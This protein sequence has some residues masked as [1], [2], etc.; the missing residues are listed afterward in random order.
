MTHASV[1]VKIGI[2]RSTLYRHWPDV[3]EMRNDLFKRATTPPKMAPPTD[4]PLRTDLIWRLGILV[5]AL[6]E[7][8]WGH[9]APQVI[10]AAATDDGARD[11]IT[12]FMKERR[13]TVRAVFATADARGELAPAA[14]VEYLIQ[15][16]I[17]VPYFRKLIAGLPIDHD[18]LDTHVDH[19]C[20]LAQG[21]DA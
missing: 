8:P 10:S 14:A 18:W 1:S 7:M 12:Q 16:A 11:V 4:G 15:M 21:R 5:N 9:I 13:A 19:I 3:S 17:L 2:S 6:N 20:R